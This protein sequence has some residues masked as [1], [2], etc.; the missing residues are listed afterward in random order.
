MN[1]TFIIAI[2][3]VLGVII[4]NFSD[5]LNNETIMFL[6]GLSIVFLSMML[7]ILGVN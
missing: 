1:D 5:D 3:G 4:L 2:I 7:L 6:C